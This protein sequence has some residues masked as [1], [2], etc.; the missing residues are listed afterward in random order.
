VQAPTRERPPARATGSALLQRKCAC[1]GTPGIDGECAACK[2]KRL[3][4][5]RKAI[6]PTG[7]ARAPSI[8]HPVIRPTGRPPDR[9]AAAS[10][11]RG[12]GHHFGRTPLHPRSAG[13]IQTKL[14]ID[15]PGD[16]HEQ[17]ADRVADQ[18]V[19]ASARPGLSAA[20]PRIQRFSG[21]PTGSMDAAPSSVDRVLADPGRPMEP[22][23]QRDMERRF[24]YDF[25]RVRLHTDTAAGVSA[26]ECNARAY[27]VGHAIVFGSGQ[28]APTSAE[29]ERLLAHELAHVVQQHRGQR[30]GRSAVHANARDRLLEHE[31][32]QQGFLA[33][34]GDPVVVGGWAPFGSIQRDDA[35]TKSGKPPPAN[36][37]PAPAPTPL[38]YDFRAYKPTPLPPGFTLADVKLNLK[39]AIDAGEITSATATG[40][41]AGST[42]EIFVLYALWY[43]AEKNRWGTEADLVTAIG[44]PAKAG[45][46]EPQGRVTVRIDD[47]GAASAE[48]VAAG[49]VPRPPQTTVAAASARLKADYKLASV[50][51]D[52]TATWTDAQISDVVAALAMVP[53][54][55]KLAL[56]GVELIRVR[57]LP[58]GGIAVFSGGGGV[59]KGA[60]KITE[61][62]SLKLSDRAFP[63]TAL[64][65]VGGKAKTVPATFH[66]IL[67]E[68]GHAVETAVERRA[69]AAYDQAIIESNKRGISLNESAAAYTKAAGDY[70]ALYKRYEAARKAGDA[71]LENALSAQ[72][73]ALNKTMGALLK[74]NRAR[75]EENRKA[76]AA[77]TTRKAALARTR[78]PP[79]VVAPFKAEAAK[80]RNAA[81]AAL[82]AARATLKTMSAP[83]VTSGTAYVKSVED[84]ATAI[85]TF[86]TEA[87]A[88]AGGT[89]RLETTV[90]AQT[91]ARK[92]ARDA[93]SAASPSHAA[94]TILAPVETAQDVWLEAERALAG[95]ARRSLRLQEFVDLVTKNKIDRFTEYSAANWRLKPEEFY[96]EAYGLWLTD[97]EYL[98]TNY[99]AVY[100]FFQR[101]VPRPQKKGGKP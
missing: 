62:P 81:D 13:P 42:E 74:A 73:L 83:D 63:A 99:Q 97:P 23:L 36:P 67:H 71:K 80:E 89:T 69:D 24:G 51:D 11:E 79:A 29:G 72:L 93:L 59:A 14:P 44:W 57:T 47:R 66:T 15:R 101:A 8:V 87:A 34:R 25:S 39:K 7:L 50:R 4:L 5:Q 75:G 53:A 84:T 28:F 52:G 37:P 27:T 26:R 18:V 38:K 92:I 58:D 60:T 100:E 9:A 19:A 95:A 88:M 65:F 30:A 61:V 64:R 49:P 1:G 78:V 68:V 98:G 33:A 35:G 82:N 31:A 6:A 22:V 76:E 56:Q 40:V 85:A 16:A 20:P 90:L 45:D 3:G 41:T 17:E 43:L 55:D 91:A 46:P 96:A 70:A 2:A 54:A 94:L 48:L 21:Q 10:I 86:A 77:V 12:V 32:R